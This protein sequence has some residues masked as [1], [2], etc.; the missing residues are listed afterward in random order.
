MVCCHISPDAKRVVL[1]MALVNG[2]KYSEIQKL[3]TVSERATSCLCNLYRRMGHVI[4]KQ[5]ADGRP[6]MLNGFEASVTMIISIVFLL[7]I[8]SAV[9]RRM[10]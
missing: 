1:W 6:R 4:R 9:S 7:F 8:Y 10:Y 5:Y 3:T 2:M